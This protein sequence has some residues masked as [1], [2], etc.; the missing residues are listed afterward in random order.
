MA[1]AFRDFIQ[2][3]GPG[4]LF[5]NTRRP[6]FATELFATKD[7]PCDPEVQALMDS[8]SLSNRQGSKLS[9]E[10]SERTERIGEGE[11]L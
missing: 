8:M 6:G 10:D 2:G 3:F 7:V 9:V 1:S 5:S 11:T 4:Y